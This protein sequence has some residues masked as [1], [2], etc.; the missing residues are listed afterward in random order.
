VWWL[1]GWQRRGAGEKA[2][3]AHSPNLMSKSRKRQ[4]GTGGGN[5]AAERL[6][7]AFV[8]KRLVLTNSGVIFSQMVC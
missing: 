2:L 7:A 3:G 4:Y 5:G 1:D 8:T 6:C